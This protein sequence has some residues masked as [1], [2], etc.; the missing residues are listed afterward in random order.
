[1]VEPGGKLPAGEE[2]PSSTVDGTPSTQ[3]PTAAISKEPL[4]SH[5][6]SAG[7]I[8]GIV[9]GAVAGCAILVTVSIFLGSILG[10]NWKEVQFLRRDIH[11]EQRKSMHLK[12][13]NASN[14]MLPK[15]PMISYDP[16]LLAF[17]HQ[18]HQSNNIPPYTE[19]MSSSRPLTAELAPWDEK[20][21]GL[22]GSLSEGSGPGRDM[23]VSSPMDMMAPGNG[24]DK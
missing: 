20:R 14:D 16:T 22:S 9:I 15:S 1:M 19:N 7:A 21:H 18:S 6:L 2:L 24:N 5:G 3:K 13:K 10:R 12:M 11:V 4:R 17:A 8:A 23:S